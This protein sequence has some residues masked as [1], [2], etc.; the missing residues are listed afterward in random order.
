MEREEAR[1]QVREIVNELMEYPFAQIFDIL[2]AEQKLK[3]I[4]QQCP[5][6]ID[7]LIGLMFA[8]IML[9]RR[10]NALALSKKIWEIGGELSSFFELIYSDNLLN[11]GET[12]KAGILLQD[13]LN[14][15]RNNLQHFYM[16]LIKYALFSGNLA[17]LKQIGDYPEVYDQ[18]PVLF[19][20][21]ADHAFNLSVKDYRAFIRIIKE[22]LQDCLCAWEYALHD[23]GS[24]ELLLYTSLDV[25]QN[26]SRQQS[27]LEKIKGYFLSMQQPP[28][29]DI[30]FRV[31]NIKLHPAWVGSTNDS[32]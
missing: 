12:E 11:L 17:L 24:L 18:E 9:G 10:D 1:R 2:P 19:D 5:D 32:A 13:R 30:F 23:D 26:T 25:P 16:V 28:M 4:Y 3:A 29:H 21:A 15:I 8:N 7:A 14:H 6:S 22:G 31:L 20:F 27:L